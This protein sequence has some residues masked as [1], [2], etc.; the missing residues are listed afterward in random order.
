MQDIEIDCNNN[1]GI[2]FPEFYD[3]LFEVV[4][5]TTKSKLVVENMKQSKFIFEKIK[6][7]AW[8][9]EVNLFCKRHLEESFQRKR[10]HK[11]M[12]PLVTSLKVKA[13]RPLT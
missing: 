2:A 3:A 8:I 10:Y 7:S 5:N 4:D 13:N 9:N 6:E 12:L 11:W 1:P